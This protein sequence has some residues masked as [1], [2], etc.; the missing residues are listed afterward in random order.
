MVEIIK[1]DKGFSILLKVTPNAKK[2]AI[3]GCHGNRLKM[4]V[5]SPPEDGK[6]NKA[7][8]K[9]LAKELDIKPSQLEIMSGRASREKKLH[10]T[11]VTR[12]SLERLSKEV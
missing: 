12:E 1:T 7:V 9:I 4:S 11:G 2:N 10:I 3:I 6:A 8:I 5:L